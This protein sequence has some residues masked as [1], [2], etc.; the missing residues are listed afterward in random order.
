MYLLFV[1][2]TRFCINAYQNQVNASTI[3][4]MVLFDVHS[5]R[6]GLQ[7]GLMMFP[8]E[9]FLCFNEMMNQNVGHQVNTG[10][11]VKRRQ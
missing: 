2:M 6:A 9:F 8:V 5:L 11:C 1:K 7:G 4:I 10:A 3:P